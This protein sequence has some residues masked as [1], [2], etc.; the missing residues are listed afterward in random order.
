[1]PLHTPCSLA[2]VEERPEGAALRRGEIPVDEQDRA[3]AVY[4]EDQGSRCGAGLQEGGQQL[5][6]ALMQ[7]CDVQLHP[8]IALIGVSGGKCPAQLCWQPVQSLQRW[9]VSS[10]GQLKRGP[11]ER[12]AAQG[13]VSILDGATGF[14]LGYWLVSSQAAN[15]PSLVTIWYG[16]LLQLC[17]LAVASVSQF[18]WDS[19]R[20]SEVVPV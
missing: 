10:R 6:A 12:V 4:I 20:L 17:W 9:M 15:C 11:V 16:G 13:V 14:L 19:A 2:A 7:R 5:V 1:M 3:T 8:A 18:V